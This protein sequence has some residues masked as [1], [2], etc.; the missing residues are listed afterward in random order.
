MAR[1]CKR[2]F[3]PIKKLLSVQ[4]ALNHS[5]SF[6]TSSI[7]NFNEFLKYTVQKREVT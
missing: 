3:E 1:D 4:S 5:D 6:D 2:L 7:N